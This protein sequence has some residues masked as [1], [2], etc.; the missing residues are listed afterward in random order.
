M[1]STANKTIERTLSNGVS[2]TL[3]QVEIINSSRS[4]KFCVRIAGK[5]KIT[6]TKPTRSS[7]KEALE[8]LDSLADWAI[9]KLAL[10]PETCSLR[11]WLEREPRLFVSGQE[12]KVF[13]SPSRVGAFFVESPNR[14]EVVFLSPVPDE[15]GEDLLCKTFRDFA[16][17]KI[18]SLVK[19]T[20]NRASVEIASVSV[21][22]Q[23]G[24]WGSRSSSGMISLNWRIILLPP[25]LQNYVVCHELAHARFMDHSVSFWIWLNSFCPRAKYWDRQLSK[26]STQL[27]NVELR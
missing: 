23:S 25:E 14:N 13:L 20:A 17:K 10:A 16:S 1:S 4:R 18:L 22:D 2:S 26:V 9:E 21:R 24:R 12:W 19:E 27:F 11:Q 15:S 6:L 8:F 3:V 7:L 5:G